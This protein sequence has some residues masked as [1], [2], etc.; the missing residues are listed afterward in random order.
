MV[1][2]QS[3]FTQPKAVNHINMII[4]IYFFKL[5]DNLFPDKKPFR[6]SCIVTAQSINVYSIPFVI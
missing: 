2:D 5:I 4:G 3:T 1:S 6:K